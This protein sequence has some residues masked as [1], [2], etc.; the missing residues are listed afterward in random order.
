VAYWYPTHTRTTAL[1]AELNSLERLSGEQVRHLAEFLPLISHI[2]GNALNTE[3]FPQH[4][5]GQ[6]VW[7]ASQF[8]MLAA[9]DHTEAVVA[10]GALNFLGKRV[11]AGKIDGAVIQDLNW[12]LD[13]TVRRLG[14][15]MRPEG[16]SVLSHLRRAERYRNPF[17]A[18]RIDP[19]RR[20]RGRTTRMTCSLGRCGE[21]ASYAGNWVTTID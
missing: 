21:A 7:L 1:E 20:R 16:F 14:G 2:L 18:I 3:G 5:I 17:S 4:Q 6:W 13:S 9:A 10:G 12:V 8:R 11:D 15:K 19:P